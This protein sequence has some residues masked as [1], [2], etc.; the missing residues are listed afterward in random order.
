MHQ[1]LDSQPAINFNSFVISL[2]SLELFSNLKWV[3]F[4]CLSCYY[5][6]WVRFP[7]P[8]WGRLY[9]AIWTY[10]SYLNFGVWTLTTLA[11]SAI[12]FQNQNDQQNSLLQCWNYLYIT[13]LIYRVMFIGF[14]LFTGANQRA[15]LFSPV[16]F[17][18]WYFHWLNRIEVICYNYLGSIYITC[19]M[20]W[21][22]YPL[23]LMVYAA[24]RWEAGAWGNIFWWSKWL[25]SRDASFLCHW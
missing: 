11:R 16:F 8:L 23:L 15:C 7:N 20:Y 24:P 22:F 12:W 6:H 5:W 4:P 1:S 9:W 14:F 3:L 13:H 19:E 25:W 2:S 17:G 21:I 18:C 10:Q